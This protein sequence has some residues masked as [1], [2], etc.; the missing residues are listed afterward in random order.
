MASAGC[1]KI[2]SRPEARRRRSA[3]APRCQAGA[4]QGRRGGLG[5]PRR[6]LQ[7][8]LLRRRLGRR[9]PER[10]RPGLRRL[11]KG[12]MGAGPDHEDGRHLGHLLQG[13][14]GRRPEL[15]PVR[16]RDDGDE[17]GGC[18]AVCTASRSGDTI[19]FQ[20]PRRQAA[21][22]H[23]WMSGAAWPSRLPFLLPSPCRSLPFPPDAGR[24]PCIAPAM[25][26][27]GQWW[28]HACCEKARRTSFGRRRQEE[29][30]RQELQAPPAGEGEHC[31]L[32]LG[33]G[34]WTAPDQD[35]AEGP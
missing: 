12:G 26:G 3:S 10:E 23:A 16:H 17:D 35:I 4:A 25:Q 24:L 6:G 31:P 8:R 34:G 28:P 30:R 15:E 33:T 22:R 19:R 13:L 2:S 14:E 32:R 5:R 1:R 18:E 7:R 20:A 9:L 27:Q 11:L 29:K 21:R